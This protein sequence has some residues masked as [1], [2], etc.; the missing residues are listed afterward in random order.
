MCP[1]MHLI[2]YTNS[3]FGITKLGVG[4]KILGDWSF[5][6][7]WKKSVERNDL[8]KFFYIYFNGER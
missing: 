7:V 3:V 6:R 5:M 1:A 4:V 8:M 2:S